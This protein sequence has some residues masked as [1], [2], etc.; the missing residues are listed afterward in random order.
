MKPLFEFLSDKHQYQEWC[1]REED[2][3]YILDHVRKATLFAI[4]NEL[5]D[6]QRLYIT[7]YIFNCKTMAEIAGIYGVNKS[8]VSRTIAAGRRRLMRCLRY[9]A[10]WLLNAEMEKRNKRRTK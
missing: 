1:E 5:T 6:T 10:P 9:S 7:Q 3:S 4:E 2:P 8:T